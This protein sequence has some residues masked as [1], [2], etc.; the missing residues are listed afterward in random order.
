MGSHFG[1]LSSTVT[2]KNIP[3]QP[4]GSLYGRTYQRYFG[5]DVEDPTVLDKDR[6]I[7]IGSN[8][9]PVLNP[10]SKQQYIANSQPRWIGSLSSTL[11]YKSLSLYLLLDAQQGVYRYNQF[12]N[13][14][15]SF[16]LQKSSENRND[17]IVFDGV[18]ADGSKNTKEVWL[19]QGV[20][21]DGVDYGNGYYRNYY[22]GDSETFI[23]DASWVRLRT[24]ALSYSLPPSF[25]QR[26]GFI[27][28]AS[29]T[30]TGNN[31]WLQTEY[32]T[33]DPEASSF[34]SGSY[35]DGFSGFTYPATRNYIFSVNLTF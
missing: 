15:G 10:A 31:L 9:F 19:G 14:L 27:S 21:P 30:F 5:N 24:L 18:L 25:V 35:V 3:G 11:R 32:S 6:P 33:F 1:Y 2:Q 28:G 12:A 34:S 17:M 23:E 7:V 26:S 16:A 13:F 29:I 22:R 20:G 8:G 4:V